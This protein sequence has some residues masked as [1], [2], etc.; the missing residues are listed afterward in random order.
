MRISELTQ[1]YF[2]LLNDSSYFKGTTDLTKLSKLSV[3]SWIMPNLKEF[4]SLE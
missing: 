4:C 1:T 2:S 3:S